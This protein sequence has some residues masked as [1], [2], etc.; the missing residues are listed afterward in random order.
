MIK[1]LVTEAKEY[2]HLTN[3]LTREMGKY[4]KNPTDLFNV[5]IYDHPFGNDWLIRYPGQ[6]IGKITVN[7][8]GLILNINLYKSDFE[9]LNREV[10]KI[11]KKYVGMKLV[12][13][14]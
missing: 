7:K 14:K 8:E 6:T 9:P 2:I 12:V 13:K 1:E 5:Y 3:D 11:F 10:T 4:V